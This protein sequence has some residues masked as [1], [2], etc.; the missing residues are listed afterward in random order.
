LTLINLEKPDALVIAGDVFHHPDPTHRERALFAEFLERC[1][2]PVVGIAGNHDR[3]GHAWGD[4]CLNWVVSIGRKS[5]HLF[6]DKPG[7]IC[8]ANIAWIMIP[9]FAWKST[10]Y[11]LLVSH[12][13]AALPS[14]WSGPVVV[15]AH[16]Y[17]VGA[18]MDHGYR[19]VDRARV[20]ASDRVTYYALGDIHLRQKIGSRQYYCGAP[21]QTRFGEILPKGVV[22]RDL[23]RDRSRFVEITSPKSLVKLT[24]VPKVW[25]DAHVSLALSEPSKDPLPERVVSVTMDRVKVEIP[26]AVEIASD[27]DSPLVGLREYLSAAIESEAEAKYVYGLGKK[28]VERV[29]RAG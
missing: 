21:Y 14:R 9:Y 28:L 18:I 1:P 15:V 25:P 23:D 6:F 7:L 17:F 8:V 13:L 24:E 22:F 11:E 29:W 20:P 26:T 16:A 12:Y 27:D 19:N 5:G 10:D 2:V 4:T 3:Y